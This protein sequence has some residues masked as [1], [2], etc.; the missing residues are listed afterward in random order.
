M[1]PDVGL[2]MAWENGELDEE[3]T[4]ELFQGLIDSGMAWRLQGCYGRQA[5]RLIE[6]GY[7]QPAPKCSDDP[8]TGRVYH[9]KS[10]DCPVH[11]K[12]NRDEKS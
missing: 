10:L 3:Q 2:L 5:A 9:C 1:M 8:G 12:R 7:C 11:G 4:V 6:A